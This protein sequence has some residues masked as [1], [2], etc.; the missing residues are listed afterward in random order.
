MLTRLCGGE[1]G[2]V[3]LWQQNPIPIPIRVPCPSASRW[4][5]GRWHCRRV[6]ELLG[7]F[8]SSLS[9]EALG[10]TSLR[11][12]IFLIEGFTGLFKYEIK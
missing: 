3:A 9:I 7:E 11:T 10:S 5:Y 6:R 1:S 12:M 8:K 2:F 4:E